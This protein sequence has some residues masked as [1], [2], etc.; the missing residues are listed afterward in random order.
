MSGRLAPMSSVAVPRRRAP[1]DTGAR[2]GGADQGMADR[3]YASLA[4]SS[5]CRLPLRA[6]ETGQ[7]SLG[8]LARPPRTRPGRGRAPATNLEPHLG[9]PEPVTHLLDGTR[10]LGADAGGRRLRGLEAG[11]ERHAQTGCVRGGDQFFGIG[12]FRALE[13]GRE[14]VV[15][16]EGAGAGA[17][18]SASVAKAAFPDGARSTGAH[19]TSPS[20]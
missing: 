3:I 6:C 1:P 8:L 19:V 11:G 20:W 13:P 15:P 9:D 12:A 7:P 4:S 14:R 10:R 5:I 18:L 16:A 2:Q 17:E